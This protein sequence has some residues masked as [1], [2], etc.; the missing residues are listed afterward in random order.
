MQPLEIPIWKWKYITMDLIARLFMNACSVHS[1]WFIVDRLTKST[2]FIQIQVSIS[3]EKLAEIYVREVVACYGV[4]VTLV[5]DIDAHFTS[6]F[7]KQFH[8]KIGNPFHFSTS[9]HSQTHGQNERTIQT[10]EDMLRV[11]VLDFGG[12]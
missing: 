5:S 12:S 3:V 2:H 1:I 6:R 9:F 4:P 10:L 8:D 7:W 11:R